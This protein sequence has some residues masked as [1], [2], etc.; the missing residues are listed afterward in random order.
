MLAGKHQFKIL[1]RR[2]TTVSLTNNGSSI[3]SGGLVLRPSK[4][5]LT[6]LSGTSGVVSEGLHS[7]SPSQPLPC[8]FT[9]PGLPSVAPIVAYLKCVF[10]NTSSPCLPYYSAQVLGAAGE[11]ERHTRTGAIA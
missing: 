5:R 9:P 6:T 11:R 3:G 8:H 1:E 4:C 2:G 7:H 10:K